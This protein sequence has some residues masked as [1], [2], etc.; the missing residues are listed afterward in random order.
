MNSSD[1]RWV[2]GIFD[3]EGSFSV[4]KGD[5]TRAERPA[6]RGFHWVLNA[7]IVNTSKTL[8]EELLRVTGMGHI[9]PERGGR[10]G[11]KPNWT[12]NLRHGE[13]KTL[14]PQVLPFLIVKRRQAERV[15]ESVEMFDVCKGLGP[16]P[17]TPVR[18]RRLETIFWEMRKLN[19]KRSDGEARVLKEEQ[20]SGHIPYSREDWLRDSKQV[21]EEQ[22]R[23]NYETR[24]H[25]AREW[26][27]FHKKEQAEYWL[28]WSS[29]R[30]RK[31]TV[32]L[33]L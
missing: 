18:D 9:F 16:N 5:C 1:A 10:K 3:S 22:D 8:I 4:G 7:H 11:G 12:W 32:I 24:L 30:K 25:H 17:V 26:K 14:L 33:P 20:A 29:E 27:R 28:K 19:A 21:R 2:A 31:E 23:I 6:K 13:I 15:L